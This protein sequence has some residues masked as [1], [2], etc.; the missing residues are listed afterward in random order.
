LW[1]N[2]VSRYTGTKTKTLHEFIHGVFLLFYGGDIKNYP[3]NFYP[4]YPV[5]PV[6]PVP[7]QAPGNRQG[8]RQI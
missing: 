7:G 3:I 1:D 2:F 5:Y 8:N 4:A 6:V